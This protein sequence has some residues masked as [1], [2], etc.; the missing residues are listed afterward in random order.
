MTNFYEL[1]DVEMDATEIKTAY[2][3]MALKYHPDKN[4]NLSNANELFQ[5]L[6][7]AKDVLSDPTKRELYDRQLKLQEHLQNSNKS[8]EKG[9]ETL[10]TPELITLGILS[11]C[12][13]VGSHILFGYF[14][15]TVEQ[16]LKKK[17]KERS[18][19]N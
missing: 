14:L 7:D 13:L 18:S 17:A 8:K 2:K 12:L 9:H 4:P 11:G 16:K 19:E 10:S 1:L 15:N 3:K 6:S 5:Q